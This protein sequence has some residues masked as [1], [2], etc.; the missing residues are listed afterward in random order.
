MAA[1]PEYMY[2]E[3]GAI[4]SQ[5]EIEERARVEDEMR[6]ARLYTAIREFESASDG[7]ETDQLNLDR[8]RAIDYYLGRPLGNE[9]DGRSQV[10]SKDLYD[11]VEAMLPSLLRIFAGGHNVCEFQ[12]QGDEDIQAAEQESDYINY[13]IQRKN[14]WFSIAHAWFKDALLTRNAYAYAFWD[15]ASEPLIEKYDGLTTD[16]LLLLAND[17]RVTISEH[18]ER[19]VPAVVPQGLQLQMIAQGV[20]QAFPP[21]TVHDVTL[22]KRDERGQVKI[23]V[24]PPERCRVAHT[25]SEMSVRETDFFEYIERKSLSDLRLAGFDVPDTLTDSSVTDSGLSPVDQARD[26]SLLRQGMQTEDVSGDP[27]SRRVEVRTIWIRHDYDGDGIAELRHC[28]YVGDTALQNIEVASIPIACIVPYPMPHRHIGLSEMD[29]VEDLQNIKTMMI[30]S[31]VDNQFL[32]NNGRVGVDVNTVNIDDLQVSRPL[33]LVRVSGSPHQGIFPFQ[34]PDTV[35]GALRMLEYIDAVREERAGVQKPMAGADMDAIMAQPGTVAQF[36]SAASQK[37]ELVA[38]VFAEGVKELF[39]IVHEVTLTNATMQD[40]VELRGRWV[41]VDP[42]TWKKRFDM[43]ISVGMGVGNKQTHTAGVSSLLGLQKQV[44]GLGLTDLNKIY[45]GLAE[46]TKSIGFGN[47]KQFF[48]EP[49]PGSKMPEPPPDPRVVVEQ[50]RQESQKQVE[51]FKGQ[52]D[53]MVENIKAGADAQEVRFREYMQLLNDREERMLRAYSEATERAQEER[54]E[55]ER[56][57]K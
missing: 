27:A 46:F 36:A 35:I 57:G 45:G 26:S 1:N 53:I 22:R 40:K 39:G 49:P 10:V 24:L 11:T 21:M 34:H 47:A 20:M 52:V 23:C 43:T 50:I 18:T 32:L 54:L 16:Q 7:Q 51:S 30:R 3:Q 55:R 14:N 31:A 9:I 13:V 42:R 5:D 56:T 28:V 19:Q 33:G 2:D 48:V 44:L 12:P 6:D 15:K 29:A 37:I 41:T 8:A 4:V 17:P 38:R 25:A